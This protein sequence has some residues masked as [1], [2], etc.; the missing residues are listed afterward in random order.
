MITLEYIE[1]LWSGSLTMNPVSPI[2]RSYAG[3]MVLFARHA[4]LFQNRGIKLGGD[5]FA[6]GVA[7]KHPPREVRSLTK[8]A[9]PSRPGLKLRGT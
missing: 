7:T 6:P 9:L 4:A 8:H 3:L 2:W 5:W 1:N